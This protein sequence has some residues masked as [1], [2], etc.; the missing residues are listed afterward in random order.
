MSFCDAAPAW[1]HGRMTFPAGRLARDDAV[2]D[3]IWPQ[4]RLR[5]DRLA[6]MAALR[7]QWQASIGTK[8]PPV[9]LVAKVGVDSRAC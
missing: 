8:I 9:P 7:H 5:L 2:S 1:S 4:G 3:A 6:A